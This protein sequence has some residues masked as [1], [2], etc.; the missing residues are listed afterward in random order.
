MAVVLDARSSPVEF[1]GSITAIRNFPAVS[2]PYSRF[3][4]VRGLGDDKSSPRTRKVT[5]LRSTPLPLTAS[6]DRNSDPLEIFAFFTPAARVF[7][8]QTHL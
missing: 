4:A 3:T 6:S 1:P 5:D 8:T 2:S 7:A